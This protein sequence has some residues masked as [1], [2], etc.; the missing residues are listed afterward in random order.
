MYSLTEQ[1]IESTLITNV[2]INRLMDAH[3][4]EGTSWG[5]VSACRG[6]R[7]DEENHDW[8]KTL[9]NRLKS[10]G[11]VSYQM[12]MGYYKEE[13]ME[14]AEFED[15]FLCIPR[16]NMSADE[17]KD[18]LLELGRLD[19]DNPQDTILFVKDGVPNYYDVSNG[20][21]ADW[22]DFKGIEYDVDSIQEKLSKGASAYS[23]MKGRQYKGDRD[24][25]GYN[26]N[27]PSRKPNRTDKSSKPFMFYE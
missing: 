27:Y 23:D 3:M 8:T 1:E 13:S 10:D 11:K 12:I 22:S 24:F 20:Q 21:Q 5:C 9:K 18:Y 25:R 4:S 6:D 16:P 17:L 14:N 15:S 2:S 19:K 7:T 26:P